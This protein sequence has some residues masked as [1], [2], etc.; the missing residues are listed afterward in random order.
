MDKRFLGI[1][2]VIVI[3]VA[4]GALLLPHR[5]EVV[6]AHA[7]NVGAPSDTGG[8]VAVELAR[9][10][11][12]EGCA[13]EAYP[14]KDCCATKT[15]YALSVDLLDAAIM[16]PDAAARLVARDDR[17]V[18]AGPLVCNSDVIVSRG[19]VVKSVALSQR[20]AYQEDAARAAFGE[21]TVLRPMLSS[22]IAYAIERA[23][24]DAAVMDVLD[25][26][27]IDRPK[28]SIAEAGGDITT[29]ELVVTRQLMADPAYA[30]FL[31]MV[32]RTVN[33]LNDIEHLK[34][35]VEARTGVPLSI[36]E[37]KAWKQAGTR[38]VAPQG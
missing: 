28:T 19:G 23:E 38:F 37:V 13:I 10:G 29:Y 33:D 34:A 21:D 6:D 26:R 12:I 30:E 17:Y 3:A 5:G 16:C 11:G 22:A 25:A 36:E 31:A 1:A 18:I 9:T 20:R 24:V 4:A 14:L 8:L 35:A 2:I 27:A 15:E 32:S 7:I